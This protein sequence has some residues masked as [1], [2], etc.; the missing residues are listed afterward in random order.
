MNVVNNYTF[1]NQS[2]LRGW[3]VGGAWRWQD[4]AALSYPAILGPE[5]AAIPDVAHP[6]FTAAVGSVDAWLS[7]ERAVFRGKAKWKLQLNAGNIFADDRLIAASLNGD[8]ST[9]TFRAT[10]PRTW[11]LTSTLKL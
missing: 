4:K 2:R 8:G 11:S 3:G 5:G 10:P 9:A 6:Y 7:Y 1:G